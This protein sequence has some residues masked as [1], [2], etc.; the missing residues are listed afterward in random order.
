MLSNGEDRKSH[1]HNSDIP[2]YLEI[3][4]VVL[5]KIKTLKNPANPVKIN[6]DKTE[7]FF[8]F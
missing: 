8:L 2:T 6:N 7:S 1:L 3:K 5:C 4:F